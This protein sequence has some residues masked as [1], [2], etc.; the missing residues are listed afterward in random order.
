MGIGKRVEYFYT[1]L[2]GPGEIV[3]TSD[4]RAKEYSTFFEALL[5]NMDAQELG[6]IRYGPTMR[7]ER[8]VAR[9][10]LGQQQPVLLQIALDSSAG[11]YMV[12]V[13]GAVQLE[14]AA[15]LSQT[16]VQQD[17]SS[18]APVAST[19]PASTGAS[20]TEGTAP[21]VT[22]ATQPPS[23]TADPAATAKVSKLQRFWMRLGTA[24]ELLGLSNV[25]KLKIDMKDGTSQEIGLLKVKKIAVPKGADPG[26]AQPGNEGWQRLWMNLGAGGELLNLAK[27]GLMQVQL[28]DGSEQ[29]F[30]L[31]RIKKVSVTK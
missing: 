25:G 11:E 24:S 23:L 18:S 4:V 8:R 2:A 28:K 15:T 26:T 16:P 3:L 1:F 5:F 21:V 27:T 6:V 29:Q 10:Q 14:T 17:A 22:D 12:R 20:S 19:D 7:S 30:D 9:I 31:T 13:A